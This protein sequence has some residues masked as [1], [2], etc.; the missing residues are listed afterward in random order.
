MSW[1]AVS[2]SEE[3]RSKKEVKREMAAFWLERAVWSWMAVSSRPILRGFLDK[4]SRIAQRPS[5]PVA[6][7]ACAAALMTLIALVVE[8]SVGDGC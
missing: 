6:F 8:E 1:L 3:R 7:L 2:E 4:S 5:L